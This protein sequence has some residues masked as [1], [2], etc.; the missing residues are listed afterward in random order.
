MKMKFVKWPKQWLEQGELPIEYF[1]PWDKNP[2]QRK[3]ISDRRLEKSISNRGVL[4]DVLVVAVEGVGGKTELMVVEGNRR[5]RI[6]QRMG[7][8]RLPYKR[9]RPH[10]KEEFTEEELLGA[11]IDIN[12]AMDK[13]TMQALAQL[14]RDAPAAMELLPERTRFTITRAQKTLGEDYGDY[15]EQYALSAIDVGA[16]IAAYMQV[17][18]TSLAY[19]KRIVYW[20]AKHKMTRRALAAVLMK[21]SVK[22]LHEAIDEDKPLMLSGY[23]V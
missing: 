1:I 8:K 6:A 7:L 3:T 21:V 18:E 17:P 22:I 10:G 2:P 5:L 11:V 9:F 12:M 20:V 19:R 14:S 15:V 16:R 23:S 13:W 4:V